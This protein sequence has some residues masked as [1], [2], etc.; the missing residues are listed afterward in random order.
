MSVGI[1]PFK[2]I[3][4][5]YN[6]QSGVFDMVFEAAFAVGLSPILAS[7]QTFLTFAM[8]A[9]AISLTDGTAWKR[10]IINQEKP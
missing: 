1:H 8:L 3:D 4:S 9:E 7:L 10:K 2:L 5:L 6:H